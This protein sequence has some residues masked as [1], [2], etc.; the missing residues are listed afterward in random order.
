MTTSIV[1]DADHKIEHLSA[2]GRDLLAKLRG[3]TYGET[4]EHEDLPGL[5]LALLTRAR[6]SKAHAH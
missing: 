4:R 2:D 6:Y 3:F 5:L 1:V